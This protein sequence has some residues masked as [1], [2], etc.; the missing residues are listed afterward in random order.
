MPRRLTAVTRAI[1]LRSK[2]HRVPEGY[3]LDPHTAD[4]LYFVLQRKRLSLAMTIGRLRPRTLPFWP[5]IVLIALLKII[6]LW[7]ANQIIR[8]MLTEQLLLE[9]GGMDN[10]TER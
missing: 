4:Y 5:A 9:R 7:I 6:D 3:A 8:A 2:V 1:L 10:V